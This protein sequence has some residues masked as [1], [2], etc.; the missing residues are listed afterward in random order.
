M[1]TL[2]FSVGAA[3][4]LAW[5]FTS[6]CGSDERGVREYRDFGQFCLEPSDGQRL[7]FRVTAG[8]RCLSACDENVLSCSAALDGTRIEL[9]S[10]LVATPIAD[11]R[12]CIALCA[13][14]EGTCVLDAPSADSYQFC[15]A[16]LLD[17]ETLP[18]ERSTPL[19][20]A[21]P[22]EPPEFVPRLPQ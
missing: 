8:D 11:E 5:S 13:G 15:F 7:T 16:S 18:T 2:L 4:L 1:R 12:R 22:C 21:H 6:G 19:F 9:H 20:G 3:V 17:T 14:A 10:L